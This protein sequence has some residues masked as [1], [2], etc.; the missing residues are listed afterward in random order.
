MKKIV[1]FL[2]CCF[3]AVVLGAPYGCNNAAF[4]TGCPNGSS[5]VPCVNTQTD[6]NNCG[7]CGNVCPA[8]TCSGGLC[9]TSLTNVTFVGNSAFNTA[10]NALNALTAGTTNAEN[11]N[12]LIVNIANLLGTALGGLQSQ[13]NVIFLNDSSYIS[14]VNTL[15]NLA[16]P[17]TPN[18]PAVDQGLANLGHYIAAVLIALE[19]TIPGQAQFE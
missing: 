16:L 8:G 15:V 3:L 6:Y 14:A 13:S 10:V 12:Q 2:L 18:Q 7:K 5:I 1:A 4:P 17:V 9:R 19:A 11:E